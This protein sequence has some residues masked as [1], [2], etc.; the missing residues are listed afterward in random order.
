M[1]LMLCGDIDVELWP[2]LREEASGKSGILM[3]QLLERFVQ[4][5]VIHCV[6]G[7]LLPSSGLMMGFE[8]A[9]LNSSCRLR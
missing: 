5:I 4:S 2:M 9:A 1:R 8:H 3:L 6:P 7:S